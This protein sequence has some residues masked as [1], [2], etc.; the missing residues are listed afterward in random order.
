MK[1]S[2][3]LDVLDYDFKTGYIQVYCLQTGHLK[4][5]FTRH[6]RSKTEIMIIVTEG[7]YSEFYK[8]LVYSDTNTLNEVVLCYIRPVIK[9]PFLLS[10]LL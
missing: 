4:V 8:Q 9:E 3:C 7:F 2:P 10:H 1:I 5:V 6:G